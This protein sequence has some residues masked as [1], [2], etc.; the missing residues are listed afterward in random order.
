M[1]NR[2]AEQIADALHCIKPPELKNT[3]Y[4]HVTENWRSCCVVIGK[5]LV[6]GDKLHCFMNICEG[7]D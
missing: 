3:R 4:D 2:E 7:D 5:L 1:T 6:S